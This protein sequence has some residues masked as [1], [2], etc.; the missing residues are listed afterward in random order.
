LILIRKL[1]ILSAE[2]PK[3]IPELKFGA[4]TAG[5]RKISLEPPHQVKELGQFPSLLASVLYFY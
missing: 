4:E 3:Y 5:Q 2:I 1:L